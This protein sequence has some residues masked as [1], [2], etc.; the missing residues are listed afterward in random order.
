MYGYEPSTYF[1]QG[2]NELRNTEFSETHGI[3]ALGGDLK[4]SQ[5]S[6]S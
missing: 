6:N 4:T 1:Y 2:G 3:F 5:W